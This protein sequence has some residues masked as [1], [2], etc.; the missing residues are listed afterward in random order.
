MLAER[1]LHLREH[2]GAPQAQR[3]P[4]NVSSATPAPRGGTC[5]CDGPPLARI[6]TA[7]ARL[8]RHA[9]MSGLSTVDQ[10]HFGA[11]RLSNEA[12]RITESVMI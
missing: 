1:L 5:A 6:A 10:Q 11:F 7:R 9:Q 2:Y 8:S 3:R 4:G 12:R